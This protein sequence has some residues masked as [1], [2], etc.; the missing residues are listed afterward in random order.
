MAGSCLSRLFSS[1]FSLSPFKSCL[2]WKCCKLCFRYL[3]KFQIY[4]FYLLTS[5]ELNQS[6]LL[7]LVSAKGTVCGCGLIDNRKISKHLKT[8]F[9]YLFICLFC[10]FYPFEMLVQ[11]A[12]FIVPH[13][14]SF[15]SNSSHIHCN[16][17]DAN[18]KNPRNHFTIKKWF[19]SQNNEFR[20]RWFRIY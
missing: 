1:L 19:R 12:I 2:P 6:R 18:L 10:L 16:K 17:I 7:R 11:P 13:I 3:N 20:N 8:R 4:E 14:I 5:D 9:K 15:R